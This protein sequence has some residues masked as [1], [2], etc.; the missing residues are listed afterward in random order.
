MIFMM[1][2]T[3]WSLVLLVSPFVRAVRAGAA[4]KPDG[5]ISGVIGVVLLVLSIW[6]I[7]E[8]FVTLLKRRPGKMA[9]A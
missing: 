1:I 4:L 6:L 8:T 3:L 7:I 2:M 5:W 9:A